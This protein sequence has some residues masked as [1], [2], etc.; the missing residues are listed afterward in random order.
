M[1][2]YGTCPVVTSMTP[3]SGA[4]CWIVFA[5]RSGAIRPRLPGP[6]SCRSHTTTL[7][8]RERRS[9]KSLTEA[10]R[11]SF[12]VCLP[13]IRKRSRS[14]SPTRSSTRR[15]ESRAVPA[16]RLGDEYLLVVPVEVFAP[17]TLSGVGEQQ[18]IQEWW[19]T[20][21]LPGKLIVADRI[22]QWSGNVDLEVRAHGQHSG[23]EG[24]VVAGTGGQ[25]VPRVQALGGRAVLP[26]LDVAGQQH[27][28][29]YARGR[30]QAT[31]NA[32]AAAV[33]Q[34]I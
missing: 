30:V 7:V 8:T 9:P 29:G 31:E 17:G 12:W 6:S 15:P 19:P 26:R 34:H 22:G 21:V 14:G 32:A 24:Y 13:P 27:S 16:A 1:P 33:G 20:V 3:S 4:R 28:P 25:A 5:R 11:T 10:S 23:V 18:G 2:T